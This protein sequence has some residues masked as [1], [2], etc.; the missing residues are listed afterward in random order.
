[1]F[2]AIR[3][4]TEKALSTVGGTLNLSNKQLKGTFY[5]T[6]IILLHTQ[7]H[8]AHIDGEVVAESL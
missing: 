7:I 6:F 2:Q 4:V 1:M 3:V 8:M 5:L